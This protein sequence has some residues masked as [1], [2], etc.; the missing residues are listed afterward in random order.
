VPFYEP[1]LHLLLLLLL[2]H[3]FPAFLSLRLPIVSPKHACNFTA[4]PSFCKSVIPAGIRFNLYD[5]G[6]YLIKRS[7]SQSAKFSYLIDRIIKNNV[8]LSPQAEGALRDCLLLSELT[9]D[10]LLS[11]LTTLSSN[12]S[13][14]LPDDQG[15]KVHTL[16][17]S[18]VTNQ[19][20]CYEGLTQASFWQ[21]GH[22]LHAPLTNG[23]E[24][25]KLSLS[26]FTRSWA[27]KKPKKTTAGRKLLD[28]LKVGSDGVPHW[29]NR[30]IFRVHPGARRVALQ[31]KPTQDGTGDYRTIND[32][33][34]A[35]PD[36]NDSKRGYFVIRVK[37]GVY[38]EN[39]SIGKKKKYIMMVGDELRWTIITG[40]RNVADGSTTFNSA[41]LAVE[42][43]GFVAISITVRNTAGPRK[44]QA[45]ALRSSA[46]LWAFY[47]CSFEGHQDTLYTHSLKQFYKE[48]NIYGTID[49]ILGN[50]AVVLQNC[51]IFA[52]VPLSKTNTVTAQGRTH[53]NQKTGISIHKCNILASPEL[54]RTTN[55]R[56]YLGRPWT[57]YSR[58]VIMLSYLDSLIDPAG[59][60]PW[61]CDF[62]L[63]TLYYG[64]YN[65][66]GAGARTSG[67]VK[68]PGFHLMTAND[69]EKFTVSNLVHGNSWLPKTTVPFTP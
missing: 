27:P 23:T 54:A 6:R 46:D 33:V 18:I 4:N 34:A 68:W 60:L 53:P 67:R 63:K 15:D 2:P 8:T 22:Q 21:R 39:V 45:V 65:N 26:M 19:Q 12:G 20:T 31:T 57:A 24:L 11:S 9:T 29:V 62:A 35:A 48:C 66:H 16:L 49:F 1:H 64:E 3:L 59:W 40:S 41:T 58:T 69:A 7:L 50:A 56:T 25:Y 13:T 47:R 30:D 52:R 36:N 14:D 32:A 10:Y 42:G 44:A 61:S 51:N 28:D 38:K 37:G 55:V 43:H 17:S 5:Y